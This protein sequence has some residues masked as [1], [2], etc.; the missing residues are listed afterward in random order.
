MLDDFWGTSEWYNVYTQMKKVFPDREPV[1]LTLDH[2]V[3][4]CVFELKKFPQIPAYNIAVNLSN[5]T[6][7]GRT[8]ESGD[9]SRYYG[10][11]DDKGRMMVIICRDTDLG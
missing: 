10:F 5:D 1:Q 8:S 2:P 9:P 7:T 3:F 4:H 11:Y 6:L